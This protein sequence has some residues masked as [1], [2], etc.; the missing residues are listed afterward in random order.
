MNGDG[1]GFKGTML[2]IA[3]LLFW[4]AG[5]AFFVAFEGTD[6]LGENV[7]AT[8]GGGSN[9][10]KAILGGLTGIAATKAASESGI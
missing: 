10:F 6:I 5:V 8:P 1:G 9:Y 3:I 2:A 4:L 7:P